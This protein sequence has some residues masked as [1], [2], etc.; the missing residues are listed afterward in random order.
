MSKNYGALDIFR[1]LAAI[2]VIAI[3][4]PPL[5]DISTGWDFFAVHILARLAVPFFF[6]VTGRFLDFSKPWK[7]IKKMAVIYL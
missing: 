5:E 7:Y 1:P 6:M 4:T 2:L 3:H